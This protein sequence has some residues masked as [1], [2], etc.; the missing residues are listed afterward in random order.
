MYQQLSNSVYVRE[1][2]TGA[3]E[4]CEEFLGFYSIPT[5]SA[6]D[7]TSAIVE[8]S[9]AC[10][11]NMARLVEKEFDGASNMSGHVSGVSPRLK[12]LHL[13]ARYLTY[14]RNHALNLVMVTSCNSVLD[15]RNFMDT[16]KA[17]TPFFKYSAKRKHI[18]HDYL[19]SSAQEDFLADCVEKRKYQGIP[20]LSDTWWLTRVDSIDCLLKNYKA[21]CEAVEAVYLVKVLVML[22]PFSSNCCHLNSL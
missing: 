5:I 3:L 17:L 7:I 20:V 8:L 10:G 22:I 9:S 13:N 16:L 6:A 4:V 12:E 2:S 1:K 19:K 11:L 21:V 14:F 15:I 18:L